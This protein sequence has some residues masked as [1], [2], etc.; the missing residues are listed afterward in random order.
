MKTKLT[1]I[2]LFICIF[3]MTSW[4]TSNEAYAQQDARYTHYMF[5]QLVLNPGYAGSA[6]T[7]SL[8]GLYRTQ[9][10]G[11][12]GSPQT[13]ALSGH[14]ALGAGKKIGLGGH[15]EYDEIGV[16]Q[17]FSAFGSYAYKLP[18][19][20]GKLGLGVQAGA[21][22]L[23]SNWSR[24][25][26]SQDGAP[27]PRLSEDVNRVLPNFGIGA[28]FYTK[29]YYLGVSIPHLLNN[30]LDGNNDADVAKLARQFRHYNFTGG[31]IFPLGNSL[32]LKPSFLVKAVPGNAPTQ[33]DLNVS[34]LIREILW[35]GS[36]FRFDQSPTP[37]SLNFIAGVQLKQGMRISYAYD[38]T[39]SD[40][41]RKHDGSHEIILGYDFPSKSKRII[42]PRYF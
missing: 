37:E 5:N 24:I 11:L 27:D 38:L 26:T 42:T 33:V 15:V 36:S 3:A 22:F 8:L 13:I 19:G 25:R 6:E 20:P 16:H 28:H 9:W 14:T 32:K 2:I 17:R 39:L 31:L 10:V 1:T 34:A 40:L 18:M 35:L 30:R 21:L 4:M 41:R 23:Q 12:D 29:N 7:T